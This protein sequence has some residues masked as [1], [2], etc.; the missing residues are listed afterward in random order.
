M[1]L[2]D[3][4]FLKMNGLGNEI[5]VVD[6]RP[7]PQPI[8]AADARAAAAAVAYD[9]L[10][11]IYPPRSAGTDAFVRIFNNDGSEAG[12]CGNGMRCVAD[13]LLNQSGR[14]AVAVETPAGV[15]ACWPGGSRLTATVDMGVPGLRWDQIPLA[16]ATADTRAI[17]VRVQVDGGAELAAPAAVSMGNPHAVF[18]VDDLAAWDLARLGP[19][20]EHHPM[21]PDRANVSLVSVAA[22]D[23][24]V[25]RTWERG[26]GLT[27]AC[28][29]AACASLV[30]A[31]RMGRSAREATVSVPGGDLRIA[32][33]DDGHVMMTGPVAYE[34]AGRFAADLE[35]GG[36]GGR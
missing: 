9:Q 2:S 18:F 17:D 28:G 27:R 12:A 4:P 20:V 14:A 22:R 33:R 16:A 35:A 26:A 8:T 32:W 19:L 15:L 29:S 30:C 3:Q 31:S 36:G 10:M 1:S 6:M 11:A 7:A 24:L 5:L 13:V 34:F 21:F 25:V 23:H